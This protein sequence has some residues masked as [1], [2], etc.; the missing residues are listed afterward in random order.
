MKKVG[1]LFFIFVTLSC[2]VAVSGE[3][4]NSFII[5]A[6][7]LDPNTSECSDLWWPF[8]Q[9]A[10]LFADRIG[11]PKTVLVG[12]NEQTIL[13]SVPQGG[14]SFVFNAGHSAGPAS[15]KTTCDDTWIP[16]TALPLSDIL[17]AYGCTTME[18]EGPGTFAS[19][20]K[21]MVGFVDLAS[22]ACLDCL[23]HSLP[24]LTEIFNG[25]GNGDMIGDAFNN[26]GLVFPECIDT[27]CAQLGGD[28]TIKI[29]TPPAKCGDR[30]NTY[31]SHEKSW[32]SGSLWCEH[33]SSDNTPTFPEMG[34]TSSWIC[35]ESE[36]GTSVQCSANREKRES[37]LYYLP[38]ILSAGKK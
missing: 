38:A 26:A 14:A 19:T 15:F 10:E 32:P 30:A 21:A 11:S 2:R 28:P 37:V 22:P 20:T 34:E 18:D 17:I 27:G 7:G 13:S 16:A 33:G 29:Y 23:N 36:N 5:S 9:E 1:L 8:R 25:L 24:F 35:A 12:P 31:A 6:K 4:G 3:V